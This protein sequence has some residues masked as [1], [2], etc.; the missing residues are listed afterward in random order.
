MS[1]T[2]GV[3]RSETAGRSTARHVAPPLPPVAPTFDHTK[4][5]A[6]LSANADRRAASRSAAVSRSVPLHVTLRRRH[7]HDTGVEPANSDGTGAI[8][9]ASHGGRL[10]SS[11]VP[12][13]SDNDAIA[14]VE[15]AGVHDPREQH[16]PA[17]FRDAKPSL[18]WRAVTLTADAIVLTIAAPFFA[19][20]YVARAIKRLFVKG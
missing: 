8:K 18:G 15:S 17:R 12:G 5:R 6:A 13:T 4:V 11:A 2:T 9:N 7:D 3:P 19:V 1:E 10:Q 14:A 20:W 16:G